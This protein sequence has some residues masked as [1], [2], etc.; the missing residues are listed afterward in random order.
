M[1]CRWEYDANTFLCNNVKHGKK[2]L[3]IFPNSEKGVNNTTG[4]RVFLMNE[5]FGIVIKYCFECLTEVISNRLQFVLKWLCIEMTVHVS[6]NG[7]SSMLS[8]YRTW[9]RWSQKNGNEG[10]CQCTWMQTGQINLN[11]SRLPLVSHNVRCIPS[12]VNQYNLRLLFT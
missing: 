10:K 2:H 11:C 5:V 3:T 4:S 6:C 7:F 1:G 12:Q 9:T 8:P